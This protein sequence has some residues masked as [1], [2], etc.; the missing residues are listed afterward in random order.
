M[1]QRSDLCMRRVRRQILSYSLFGSNY[2]LSAVPHNEL[3]VCNTLENGPQLLY[4]PPEQP[5]TGFVLFL[6]I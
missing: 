2:N 5:R 6:V 3:A 1:L 4:E